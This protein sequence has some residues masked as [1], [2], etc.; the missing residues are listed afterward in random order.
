MPDLDAAAPVRPQPRPP[1]GAAAVRAPLRRAGRPGRAS[2]AR[3]EAY[4]NADGGF[5]ADG[6]RPAHARQPALGRAVRLRGP[7]GDRAG[8]RHGAAH[9]PRR[10]TGSPPSPTTT[11]A[12]RSSCPPPP[13]TPHAPW[14]APTED[15]PSSLLMT[16]GVAAAAY[17]LGLDHPWLATADDLRLGRARRPQAERPLR[18]PLHG[19]LPRRRPGPRPRRRRARCPAPTAC[20]TTA[21]CAS[22]PASRARRSARWRSRR[23]PTTPAAASS[24]AALIDARARRARG[25]PAGRRRLGLHL[26]GLE[27]RRRL[28]VARDGDAPARSPPCAPT[29]G[30]RPPP[31]P[32]SPA[33]RRSASGPPPRRSP[34]GARPS[35]CPG[36]GAS[37]G[38]W[39][40][41]TPARPGRRWRRGRW[42]I[43]ST[44]PPGLASSPAASGNHGMKPMPCS[45][46]YAQDVLGL[47][48]GQVVEVLH[49]RDLEDLLGGLDL[50]DRHLAEAEVPDEA[51][52]L[53]GLELAELLGARRCARRCGA[54]GTGRSSRRRS[55]RRLISA[56]WRRYSR[57]PSCCQS[58]GPVAREAA[59][60]RDRDAV[61][62][63]QRLARCSPR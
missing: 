15:P 45:S 51:L 20:P 39:P 30:S 37:R 27:P 36:S 50:V 63:R 8:R 61:V 57:R 35:P 46:Q 58:P 18:L 4:K 12:S 31:R 16:A 9:R 21:S 29:A 34:P 53:Q 24:R 40:A 43:A 54:A 3:V 52:V 17:R 47:A 33:R 26:G 55:R 23:A 44:A 60:G 42:A 10:W 38:T 7:G 56:H 19:A 2:C 41:A 62:G 13:A 28:G 11:A 49:R 1:A 5:G 6:A 14:W 32:A 59:L 25:R 48:G 22:R